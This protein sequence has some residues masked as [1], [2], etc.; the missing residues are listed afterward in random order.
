MEITNLKEQFGDYLYYRLPKVYRDYDVEIKR[1]EEDE[2]G[3]KVEN[4]YKTL[5]EYLR[6]FALGG[7][8]PML[9]DL[10][11]II[12]LIDPATCP[13]QFLPLMLQHFGLDYIEDIP[14]KFQR[15]LLQNAIILYKKKGTLPAVVFLARE[16]SGFSVHVE[17][18]ERGGVA[19]AL[20]KLDAYDNEDAELLL[21]QSVIQRYIH[22]FLP[23][24]AQSEVVVTYGYTEG[25]HINSTASYPSD[26]DHVKYDV[27]EDYID[28]L[29]K[30][31]E[32]LY[33]EEYDVLQKCVDDDFATVRLINGMAIDEEF[34]VYPFD[35]T[36]LTNKLDEGDGDYVFTNGICTEDE[37]IT[38][39]EFDENSQIVV[40]GLKNATAEVKYLAGGYYDG[41]MPIHKLTTNIL[42]GTTLEFRYGGKV[43]GYLSLDFDL[44]STEK[45]PTTFQ[46]DLQNKV[47][48][49]YNRYFTETIDGT[50]DFVQNTGY[51]SFYT[52]LKNYPVDFKATSDGLFMS[53]NTIPTV[54]N[55]GYNG[56]GVVG[57]FYIY[58]ISGFVYV[59]CKNTITSAEQ[60]KAYFSE[61]PLTIT[62]PANYSRISSTQFGDTKYSV[63]GY[64]ISMKYLSKAPEQG[65]SITRIDCDIITLEDRQSAFTFE[66][67][68]FTESTGVKIKDIDGIEKDYDLGIS[69]RG[70]SE[71]CDY[72]EK[73]GDKYYIHNF[74]KRYD[75]EDFLANP[76]GSSGGGLDGNSFISWFKLSKSVCPVL[77]GDYST[78]MLNLRTKYAHVNFLPCKGITYSQ[79]PAT[80]LEDSRYIDYPNRSDIFDFMFY[81]GSSWNGSSDV[82]YGV[83]INLGNAFGSDPGNKPLREYCQRKMWQD[84]FK[85]SDIEPGF[86]FVGNETVT[87]ITDKNIINKLN[88]LPIPDEYAIISSRGIAFSEMRLTVKS[89]IYN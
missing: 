12:S 65:A 81:T 75:V 18:T 73:V 70:L 37:I 6:A 89:K 83:E 20:V 7:F 62:A 30:V 59:A 41:V 67:R 40:E 39:L 3:H 14:V 87:E 86:F 10:E 26:T 78:D 50:Y 51:N 56:D 66:N 4:T 84:C 61:N 48:R 45:Y 55:F 88:L 77:S 1:V 69:L 74:I 23:T 31:W 33:D 16:L 22:L 21:A 19:F 63:G 80:Y 49:I 9:E 29:G 44:I 79:C 72:I 71:Y 5:Q 53:G 2:G 13:E 42:A 38:E 35:I 82:S 47:V 64:T 58:I 57:Q 17:E 52:I 27:S 24:T 54:S 60:M 68:Y 32:G 28:H 8:Q 34:Y 43:Y 46:L 25:I 15:R 85:H 11:A 36:S 76:S